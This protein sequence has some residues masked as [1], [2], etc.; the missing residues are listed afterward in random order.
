MGGSRQALTCGKQTFYATVR[1]LLMSGTILA[2]KQCPL[3]VE[4]PSFE[5]VSVS[6]HKI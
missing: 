5:L 3:E 4:F 2:E 1:P 6:V